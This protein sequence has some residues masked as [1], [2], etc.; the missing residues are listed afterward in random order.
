[1]SGKITKEDILKE[2]FT[3]DDIVIK[4]LRKDLEVIQVNITEL[5]ALKEKI[6]LTITKLTT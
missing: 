1:M 2:L 4:D 5:Q 3:E 6:E